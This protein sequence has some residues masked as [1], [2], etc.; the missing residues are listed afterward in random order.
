MTKS[1]EPTKVEDETPE[2]EINF[3]TRIFLAIVDRMPSPL[4]Q[5]LMKLMGNNDKSFLARGFIVVFLIQSV[6]YLL[7]YVNLVFLARWFS[8]EGVGYYSY[9]VSWYLLLTTVSFVGFNMAALKFIPEYSTSGDWAKLR[10]FS[11]FS[12]VIVLVVS[13]LSTGVLMAY[14]WFFPPA[15]MA[16]SVLLI[17]LLGT[18][19][20]AMMMLYQFKL[21]ALRFITLAFVP[22]QV[23]RTA[24]I[25]LVAF[26]TSQILG[27]SLETSIVIALVLPLIIVY[28]IQLIVVLIF[29]SEFG[30][31][32]HSKYAYREWFET[33]VPMFVMQST[34]EVNKR[35]AIFV[36]GAILTAE[37]VGLYS[38]AQRSALIMGFFHSS[39]MAIFAPMIS[40]LVKQKKYGKLQQLVTSITRWLIWV[41]LVVGILM[42]I[43]SSFILSLFGEEFLAARTVF[44][45]I[46]IGQMFNTLTGPSGLLL[47]LGGHERLSTV[48]HITAMASLV[49]LNLLLVPRY[50]IIGAAA[51]QFVGVVSLNI[52]LYI[53]V[54]RQMGI[55]TVPFL[56]PRSKKV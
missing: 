18:P 22:S 11:R 33:S 21:R 51:A 30:L 55:H 43:F 3:I 23:V 35:F 39:A 28:L 15:G 16:Q 44:I 50:G 40:P 54:T 8:K 25:T 13:V 53:G 14:L 56:M 20:H 38:V 52:M 24:L 12:N 10:G 5:R 41:N 42:I 47:N 49:V 27:L 37:M 32:K 4:Q 29:R 48:L 2:N 31:A 26:V 7:S 36:I 9:I 17:A 46:I 1:P 45:I 19:I 6:S 34:T